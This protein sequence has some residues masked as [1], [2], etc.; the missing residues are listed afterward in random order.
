MMETTETDMRQSG[1][2]METMETEHVNEGKE[3]KQD[4]N[5]METVETAHKRWNGV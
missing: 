3:W 5:M 1:N 2:K 4:G